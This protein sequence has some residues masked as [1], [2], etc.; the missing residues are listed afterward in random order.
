MKTIPLIVL[1]ALSAASSAF[2]AKPI[3]TAYTQLPAVKKGGTFYDLLKMNPITLN[4]ILITNVEDREISNWLHLPL[5]IIDPDTYELVPGL[6][7]KVEMSKDKK[8]YT[9]TMR[10]EA[11]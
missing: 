2:G 8:E 1:C 6:A 4:P 3:K 11:K 7:E 10:K 5:M 9:F